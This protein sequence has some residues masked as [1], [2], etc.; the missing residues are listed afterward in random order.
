MNLFVVSTFS[1]VSC[2][3]RG[4]LRITVLIFPKKMNPIIFLSE[5]GSLPHQLNYF[6]PINL[7]RT[8]QEAKIG[9]DKIAF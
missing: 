1:L 2:F 5:R 9:A 4:T 3:N 6:L 8:K 7:L